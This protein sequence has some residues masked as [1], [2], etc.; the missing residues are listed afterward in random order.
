MKREFTELFIFK[1]RLNPSI[2]NLLPYIR[3]ILRNSLRPLPCLKTQVAE[4]DAPYS[5]LCILWSV[6]LEISFF[7]LYIDDTRLSLRYKDT[8]ITGRP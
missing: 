6:G 1:H 8:R 5:E 2:H 3:D 7:D 4:Q